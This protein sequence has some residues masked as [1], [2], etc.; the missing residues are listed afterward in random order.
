MD[1]GET[2]GGDDRFSAHDGLRFGTNPRNLD[3]SQAQTIASTMTGRIGVTSADTARP[4]ETTAI[5]P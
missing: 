4:V 2:R 1:F 3:L 5:V